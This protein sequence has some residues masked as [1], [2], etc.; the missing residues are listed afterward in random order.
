MDIAEL[1]IKIDSRSVKT[2]NADLDKFVQ[3]G[4]KAERV[5]NTL[6]SRFAAMAGVSLGGAAIAQ[7][8]DSYTELQNRIRLV[9]SSQ[10][11][12]V[13]STNAVFDIA[14]R[15]NQAVGSTG[16]IYQRFAQNAQELGISMSEVAGIT[17]TVSKAVAISGAS[18]ASAD[19]ALVQLGQALASGVLRGEEFNSVMEQAPGLAQAIATGLGVPI[20]SLRALAAAGEITAEKLIKALQK[21]ADSVDEKFST[22][23]VTLGQAFVNL[24]TSITKYIGEL[25]SGVGATSVLADGMNLLANNLDI[26]VTAATAFTGLKL[27]STILNYT[28]E[29]VK[30]GKANADSAKSAMLAAGAAKQTAIAH[31][32]EAKAVVDK[33]RA[34]GGSVAAETAYA[35]AKLNTKQ[36]TIAATAATNAYTKAVSLSSRALSL[37]GGPIGALTLAVTA[38]VS[39]WNAYSESADV[40]RGALVNLDDSLESVIDKFSKLNTVERERAM[41]GLRKALA[42]AESDF[43]RHMRKLDD[44]GLKYRNNSDVQ[45]FI[46]NTRRLK[47]AGLPAQELDEKMIALRN[48]LAEKLGPAFGNIQDRINDVISSSVNFVKA[49]DELRNRTDEVSKSA[50]SSASYLKKLYEAA[51]QAATGVTGDKWDKF[52]GD[53]NR[54]VD[55]VGMN[56]RQMA[57]YTAMTLGASDMQI[58]LAGNIGGVQDE[59]KKLEQA[60]VDG[61]KKAIDGSKSR[62]NALIAEQGQIV[63]NMTYAKAYFDMLAMGVQAINAM[64]GAKYL[65]GNESFKAME[66]LRARTDKVIAN[67]GSNTVRHTKSSGGGLK[68]DPAG[69][70]VKQLQEQIG[71]LGKVTEYEKALASIQLGKYGKINEAQKNEILGYAQ[72]LDFMKEAQEEAEKY[73]NFIDDITGSAALREHTQQ[74]DWLKKAWNEG[75]LSAERY[76]ELVDQVTAKF[77]EGTGT[78]SEFA[79]QASA[80]IQDTL[81]NTLA[82]VLKGNFDNIGKAWG[83]MILDMVAQAAAANLNEALFG[84]TGTGGLI[85]DVLGSLFGGPALGGATAASSYMP[86]GGWGTFTGPGTFFADGGYTGSGGKYEPAGI[87]HKG[88]VVFSQDDVRKHGGVSKVE[89]M[90]LRGYSSGGV[91]GGGSTAPGQPNVQVNVINNGQPMQAQ[92]NTRF[93]GEKMI[94]DVVLKDL[95][96]NGPISKAMAGVR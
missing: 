4:S 7:Y 74:L 13:A 64:D 1:G 24:Q 44:L 40:V 8:A 42:D 70:Y 82:D 11:E 73:Q 52:I 35:A 27:G 55:V 57:E 77:D 56:A 32:L 38:G 20:G 80:N 3:S 86:S 61:N 28:S 14:L 65:A 59:I 60:T 36:A 23:V 75:A 49:A 92:T 90:R 63:Y 46:E 22:R 48:T 2:A 83:D 26:V 96:V 68:T 43:D 95:Y 78:M 71:L 93:D 91:V 39:I 67:I 72:T 76:K 31:E 21:A 12:L 87:V 54:S 81:G 15:T 58:A 30:Y 33:T 25:N 84:K 85:G 37:V 53:L 9:T 88:E 19:A 50:N 51:Q 69:D 18:A 62:I 5:A 29:T 10:S 45:A 79:K 6:V 41:E 94:V 34:Y 17:D 66:E 16:Q 89:A 47:E